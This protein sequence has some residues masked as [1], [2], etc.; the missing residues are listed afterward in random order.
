MREGGIDENRSV[1]REGLSPHGTRPPLVGPHRADLVIVGGGFTGV[2]AAW[3]VGRRFP[4]RSIVLLEARELGNGASGRNGGQVLSWIAGVHPRNAAEARQI[5]DLTQ[6][7]IDLVESLAREHAPEA[8]FTRN[9][10]LEVYTR[11]AEAKR[12][13]RSLT[14]LQAAGLALRWL[15]G[16]ETGIR[17]A[18]GG[19][20]DPAAGQAN[21]LA[22][23]RGLRPVLEGMGV[24]VFESTPVLRIDE[25]AT[26]ELTTPQGR[27]RAPAIVLATNAYTPALGYFTGGILPLWSHMLASDA[28]PSERWQRGGWSGDGFSDDRDRIAF[29]C[30]TGTGRLVFG[31]GSN[32]AYEYRYA[33]GPA[34]PSRA[35]RAASAITAT[36][37]SYLPG[38]ADA[39]LPH[40]WSGLLDLSFDR[41]PSIGVRGAA[42]NVYYALGYSGH[43]FTLGMLAG[44]ILG[45]LY[46]GEHE[47]WRRFPFYQRRLPWIPSEP[48]RWLGY[49]AY[50]RLTGRSPRRR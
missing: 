29:G 14:E 28:L 25:G 34:A 48:L 19:I 2:S 24:A 12:A 11:E 37:R 16:S 26:I 10:S 20:F 38:L 45:D 40:R 42:R 4:G 8:R 6:S 7:G 9:G 22:L 30:R 23:L 1:W 49:Q 33:G 17:G 21:G 35:E 18:L 36:L 15:E 5:Y 39:P 32:S 50:T 13:R 41:A 3:H 31:G 47:P 46:A 43:G 44:R 27:V